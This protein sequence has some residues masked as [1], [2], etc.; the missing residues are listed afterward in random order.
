M[1]SMSAAVIP[2][3]YSTRIFEV[4]D[5]ITYT[6]VDYRDTFIY[7]DGLQLDAKISLAN[8]AD[9]MTYAFQIT[10]NSYIIGTNI[11]R[12][13]LISDRFVVEFEYHRAYTD[14]FRGEKLVI[15]FPLT[16]THGDEVGLSERL[17]THLLGRF[18]CGGYFVKDIEEESNF[19]Y[20]EP[21]EI[22]N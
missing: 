17:L 21:V 7:R 9:S 20:V 18:P 1:Y 6:L 11:E 15:K 3:D 2:G 22:F 12:S 16:E 13:V 8:R 4:R 19:T 5:Y 10:C 14:V